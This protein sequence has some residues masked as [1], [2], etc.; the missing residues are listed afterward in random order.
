MRAL[1]TTVGATVLG[2]MGA[3]AGSVVPVAGT[4]AGGIAGGYAGYELGDMAADWLVEHGMVDTTPA[5]SGLPSALP[6][7][8]VL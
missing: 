7:L 2:M 5:P 6:T 3:T 4:A 8:L 1:L